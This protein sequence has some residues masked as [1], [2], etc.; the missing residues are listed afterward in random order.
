MKGPSLIEWMPEIQ[1][2]GHLPMKSV[3]KPRPY[4]HVVFDPTTTLLVAASSLEATFTSYDE[5]GNVVWEPECACSL[6]CL[7]HQFLTLLPAPN[8][9]L[10]KCESSTLEL[11]APDSWVTMDG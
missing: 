1:L 3:P 5:D 11:I 2:D 8:I 7:A 9:S 4:S 6:S 10:P